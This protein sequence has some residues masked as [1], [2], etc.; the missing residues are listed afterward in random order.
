MLQILRK[1]GLDHI[2]HYGIVACHRV[3]KKD[4]HG[5]R[6]TIVRFLNRKDAIKALKGKRYLFRCKEIGYS[7]LQ[8]VENLCPSYKSIYDEMKKLKGEGT[9]A[10][11]WT[12]NGFV[13]Y[14]VTDNEQEKIKKI[15]HESEM[16]SFYK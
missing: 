16:D 12:F 13:N 10:K 14:K 9:I 3:G 11:V 6:N 8:M 5:N 1:I 7:E 2:N 15:I 4:F